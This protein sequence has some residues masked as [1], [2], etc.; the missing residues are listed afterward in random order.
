MDGV[1]VDSH[2]AHRSA[3]KEF[4][5]TLGKELSDSELDFIMDGRKRE[6]ILAHFLGPLDE[7]QL[8]N[9]GKMKNDLFSRAA[10]DV[11]PIPGVFPFIDSLEREGIEMA[12]ATSA[13]AS[14]TRFTLKRMGLLHRFRAVVTGDEVPK[15]KPDP[16]IYQL[17]C[18]R[19][20]CPPRAAVAL[21]DAASGV[22]A[23]KSAGVKCAAIADDT[24]RDLLLAAGA[25]AVLHDF[26]D[27]TPQVFRSLIGM[28]GSSIYRRGNA[29]ASPLA[30]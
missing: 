21:E 2:P 17:A 23:A 8:R 22:R 10:S 7:A 15:G 5:R 24:R 3:W 26:V 6:E 12:V 18:K 14:R 13:S 16:A 20:N 1:I 27:I 11:A 19:L 29:L 30:E 9:Y 28:N 4:L 25:D